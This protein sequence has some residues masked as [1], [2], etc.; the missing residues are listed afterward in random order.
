MFYVFSS[1]LQSSPTSPVIP[2]IIM[3]YIYILLYTY[4]HLFLFSVLWKTSQLLW[5]VIYSSIYTRWKNIYIHNIY[6]Y[7]YIYI[8]ICMYIY[9]YICIYVHIS[10]TVGD[11]GAYDFSRS[12]PRPPGRHAQ[13]LPQ[14]ASVAASAQGLRTIRC[15]WKNIIESCR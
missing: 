1:H 9:I 14:T 2:V 4:M 13:L 8:C 7:M 6:I 12:S 10:M 15:I 3:D 5:I 11:V